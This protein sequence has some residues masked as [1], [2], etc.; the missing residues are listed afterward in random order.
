MLCEFVIIAQPS[1]LQTGKCSRTGEPVCACQSRTAAEPT[2]AP[3]ATAIGQLNVSIEP[4]PAATS[5]GS[6]AFSTASAA[7]PCRF[8][9]KKVSPVCPAD[10]NSVQAQFASYGLCRL[11][12]YQQLSCNIACWHS[13]RPYTPVHCWPFRLLNSPTP[14]VLLLRHCHRCFK[15]HTR[16]YKAPELFRCLNLCMSTFYSLLACFTVR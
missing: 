4:S 9:T 10:A 3:H 16:P 7:S 6:S 13:S 1:Q 8:G 2:I 11:H 14:A 12:I 15:R 5:L